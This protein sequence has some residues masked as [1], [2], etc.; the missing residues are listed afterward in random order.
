M[1][2][3]KQIIS[4]QKSVISKQVKKDQANL[5]RRV[6]DSLSVLVASKIVEKKTLKTNTGKKEYIY[7]AKI[8]KNEEDTKKRETLKKSLTEVID[9]FKKKTNVF[10]KYRVW[11]EEWVS[12]IEANMRKDVFTVKNVSSNDSFD[13]INDKKSKTDENSAKKKVLGKRNI[14]ASKSATELPSFKKIKRVA[15][16][17]MVPKVNSSVNEIKIKCPFYIIPLKDTKTKIVEAGNQINSLVE[18]CKNEN[19]N[20][21]TKK[22]NHRKLI[23]LDSKEVPKLYTDYECLRMAKVNRYQECNSFTIFKNINQN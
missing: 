19:P 7:K 18:M 22:I 5:K 8:E 3:H 13:F 20:R 6:Y 4:S 21:Y 15:S 14:E 11:Y 10:N 17:Y 12:L 16:E 1:E 2:G 23:N 9:N